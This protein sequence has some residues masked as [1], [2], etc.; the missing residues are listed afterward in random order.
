MGG[1]VMDIGI[2]GS[3]RM[4]SGMGELWAEK[5]HRVCFSYSRD[6]ARLAAMAAAAG[7][8]SRAGTPEEA[9]DFGEA[10]VL[11][12][13]WPLALDLLVRVGSRLAGK[14]LLTCVVPWNEDRS[15]VI[16]ANGTSAAEEIAL[17]VPAA[18][19]VET[20]AVLSDTLGRS[21]REAPD[22]ATMFYC[23]ECP[24]A[25]G[26]A[27]ELIE[28]LDIEPVDAGGLRIAR[29]LEPVAALLQHLAVGQGRGTEIAL[30]LLS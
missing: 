1:D 15:G 8:G 26:T 27:A 12:V 2:I 14:T 16:L 7:N 11:A 18:N 10:V 21:R 25:K 19:V 13:P 28:D 22:R 30:K 3:G 20:L 17:Q 23:G 6:P 4:G 9:A 24:I 5:G 29:Y